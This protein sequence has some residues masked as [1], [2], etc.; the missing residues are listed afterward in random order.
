M[1]QGDEGGDE[2]EAH[3]RSV[4]DFFVKFI[5]LIVVD[6]L[7]TVWIVSKEASYFNFENLASEVTL[8]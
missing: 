4:N 3:I 2:L 7:V 1:W 8:V 6:R 5:D